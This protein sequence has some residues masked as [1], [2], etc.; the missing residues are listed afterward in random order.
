M[1]SQYRLPYF[2]DWQST[3]FI[4][5]TTIYGTIKHQV[6]LMGTCGKPHFTLIG[7]LIIKGDAML[8]GHNIVPK[9][10]IKM[11]SIN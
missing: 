6:L 4:S 3:W 2:Y 1:A 7:K 5:I 11:L 8:K 10:F 9:R